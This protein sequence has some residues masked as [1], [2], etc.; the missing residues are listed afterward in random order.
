MSGSISGGN[1][2]GSGSD[3]IVLKMSEDQ[4]A[5]QDAQFTV[6]VDGQQI[7]S[8]QTVTASHSAGQDETFTFLG[9]YSPGP[10]KVTVTFTN[11]FLYPGTSGDRNLYVDGVTYDGQTVSNST[12]PIYQSPLFPPNSWMGDIYGNAVYN[13]NDTTASS[14]SNQTTTPGAVSLGSGPDKLVLNMAE[15]PYQGDAQ[16]TVSVD[17]KQIGG[18]QTTTAV[19]SQGQSQEFDV[20]GNFGGGTHDVAVTFLNDAVGGYYPAG[21]PLAPNADPSQQWALDTADRNL[22]VMNASLDGR[23]S[24]GNTPWE[25]SSTGTQHFSVTAGNNPNAGGSSQGGSSQGGSQNGSQNGSQTTTGTTTGGTT[26]T[27]S[28]TSNTAT[29]SSSSLNAGQNTNGSTSGMNFVSSPSDTSATGSPGSGS[30]SGGSGGSDTTTTAGTSS[31]GTGSTG[32]TSTQD[33][34]VPAST[35]ATTAD[36]GTSSGSGGQWGQYQTNG[37]QGWSGWSHQ[38]S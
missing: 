13:V 12:T 16:F 37:G 7:G 10:H 15:D 28:S 29:I 6:N 1:V 26:D 33:F 19:V 38:A 24:A 36:T 11:N 9:N 8:P 2:V 14:G 25:L 30:S 27:S 5:G 35:G 3:S 4:A 22:Y 32:G 23:P 21:T 17:G 18:T 20:Y 34:T 31:G